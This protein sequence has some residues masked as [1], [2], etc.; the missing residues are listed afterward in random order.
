MKLLSIEQ[1]AANCRKAFEGVEV[2][3]FILHCHHEVLA[4][5]LDEPAERRINYI[6]V[7]KPEKEQSLRLRLFRPVS[8]EQLKKFPKAYAE[9]EKAEAEWK[10]ADAERKKAYA[11]WK[12]AEAEWKK[13]D[14]EW[15]KA[16]AEWKK[17]EAELCVLVHPTACQEGCPWDGHTIFPEERVS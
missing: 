17:A 1:E 6:L 5:R 7:N 2:G 10:K 12:K 9:R 15:E 14:A 11:E 3:A 13:A 16:Y 8:G 4:E